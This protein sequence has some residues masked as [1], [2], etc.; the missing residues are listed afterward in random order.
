MNA[1]SYA[2]VRPA[3]QA[4]VDELHTAI[5]AAEARLRELFAEET[6]RAAERRMFEWELGAGPDVPEPPP[7]SV[8][9]RLNEIR[10]QLAREPGSP[11]P[12]EQE[13]ALNRRRRILEGAIGALSMAQPGMA[14]RMANAD[15]ELRTLRDE[16]TSKEVVM[17]DMSQQGRPQAVRP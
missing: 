7:G 8:V 12:S 14:T 16:L 15:H 17:V 10:L 2:S 5:E 4:R 13:A 1:F 11:K 9:F 3:D 6:E